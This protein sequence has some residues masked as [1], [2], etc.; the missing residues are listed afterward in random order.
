MNNS[1]YSKLQLVEK[2]WMNGYYKKFACS[3]AS[4]ED[5]IKQVQDGTHK[6]SIEAFRLAKK[7]ER[8]LAERENR[9][10]KKI[11]KESY[12]ASFMPHAYIADKK[13]KLVNNQDQMDHHRWVSTGYVHIDLDNIPLNDA[14]RV[15]NA[16]MA[17]NPEAVFQSPSGDGVKVFYR[18]NMPVL[19]TKQ[20]ENFTTAVRFFVRALLE[21]L[22]LGSYYDPAA[23]DPNRQCYFSYDAN[24]VYNAGS[25]EA[26]LQGAYDALASATAKLDELF[27]QRSALS[28]V[29]ENVIT[30]A[31]LSE[32]NVELRARFARHLNQ[33]NA[34]GNGES[35][36]LACWM[37]L[38]GYD[39]VS[40]LNELT[41][42]HSALRGNWKPEEK[43]R[44]ARRKVQNKRNRYA[45]ETIE[46]CSGIDTAAYNELN[47]QITAQ[48]RYIAAQKD[49]VKRKYSELAM[50]IVSTA[51]RTRNLKRFDHEYTEQAERIYKALEMNRVVTVV[52]N[53]G[54][55]KS[56]TM[57][58]LANIIHADKN[59]EG[60]WHGMLFC[61]NTKA[62]RNAYA[63]ANPRFVIWKGT[64][65]IVEEVTQSKALAMKCSEYYADEEFEG[66]VVRKLLT[67]GLITVTQFDKIQA[68]LKA[69]AK[70]MK[71]SFVTCCHAKVQVGEAIKSFQRHV[72]VFDE[73]A[74][75]DV[76]HIANGETCKVFNGSIEVRATKESKE[77]AV[78]EFMQV[79]AGRDGG[80]VMLS[81]EKSLYR[82]FGAKDLPNLKM[83]QTYPSITYS[84]AHV[85]APKV[86]EDDSLQIVI[87][88]SLANN[89][90]AES[91]DVRDERA[92]IAKLLRSHGYFIISDGKDA[93]ENAIGDITIEGCKGSNDM[94][95]KKTAVLIGNPSPLAI[96]DMM[97]RLG[98]DE[99]TAVSVII[100][101]QANQAI[102]RNVGYRNRGGECLLVISAGLLRS[103]RALELDVLT[104]HVYDLAA[105]VRLNDA[106]TNI[107]E[108]FS[109]F[110]KDAL[111]QADQVADICLAAI[112]S[113]N[114]VTVSDMKELAKEELARCGVSSH[115][116]R[117][118]GILTAVYKLIE[119]RG[120]TKKTRR[121]G[122]K[123]TKYWII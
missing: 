43:L 90:N 18:H 42:L 4:L 95:G 121:N 49:S 74:A 26:D 34:H 46:I 36:K 112:A 15:Y 60:A 38:S 80:V 45:S 88:K 32:R 5:I 106:P 28:S 59:H 27:R 67:D 93:A 100:T 107:R 79:V 97:M 72:V 65:E 6:Q 17:T 115:E 91:G 69:N 52:E 116:L 33:S 2:K 30:D 86:L 118:S 66:S 71:S 113:A 21:D 123:E 119:S 1:I 102:G 87:V 64:S 44:N 104:P 55:G 96:G 109:G 122:T 84:M 108:M 110:V 25:A 7:T 94:M 98:C 24:A 23:C 117:R 39:D 41:K 101:D 54:S 61:T 75:D 37:V 13:V 53:A 22:D 29:V 47:E 63:K 56:R 105:K 92:T 8:D 73:M 81:A 31:V 103:G 70:N 76:M 114:G 19:T 111:N 58:E 57:G 78:E 51:E 48:E 16:I 85:G 68:A 12:V 40:I 9:A 10:V 62:N 20:K 83:K 89:N 82:A 120:A 11:D 3:E 35:F 77:T 14:K 99:D 50:H